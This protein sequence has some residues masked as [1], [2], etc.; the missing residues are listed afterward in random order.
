MAG[1]SSRVSFARIGFAILAATAATVVTLVFLGGLRGSRNEILAETYYDREVSGLSVGSKVNF[2]GV[3]IGEVRAIDFVGNRYAAKNDDNL[4]IYILMALDPRKLSYYEDE[5][6]PTAETIPYLV[7]RRGLRASVTAS[8]ITGL[9]RIECDLNEDLAGREPEKF[10]WK[11]EHLFIPQKISFLD[12]FSDAATRVMNQINTMDFGATW[13]NVHA[14]VEALSGTL[15]TAQTLLETKQGE[16]GKVVED[17]SAAA[18]ALRDF[19]GEVKANPSLL[20]RE[21]RPVPLDETR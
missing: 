20:L 9:S 6:I 19:A 7:T 18:A 16:F 2:R 14:S 1:R 13:S 5:D 4:R 17:V 12:S 8:G 21:R 11:P 15:R 3:K 10:P